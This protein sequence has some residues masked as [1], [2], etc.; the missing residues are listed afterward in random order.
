MKSDTKLAAEKRQSRIQELHRCDPAHT[1][2]LVVDMQHAF[3]DQG[4]SLEVPRGREI[5]SNIRRLVECCRA[6]G[7]PV[8]F[9]QFVYS[10]AVPC[11]RGD[12]FGIDHQPAVNG[13]ITGFGHPSSN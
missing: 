13:Q 11:L 5:V 10:P 6:E 1:A 9:T 12:P 3:L 7:A 2:L 4:A 8:I